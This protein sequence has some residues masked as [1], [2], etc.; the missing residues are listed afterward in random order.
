MAAVLIHHVISQSQRSLIAS[1]KKNQIDLKP[2]V[3]NTTQNTQN[4]I[5]K[6]NAIYLAGAHKSATDFPKVLI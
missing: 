5:K 6:Q 4:L 3:F 1:E 2:P